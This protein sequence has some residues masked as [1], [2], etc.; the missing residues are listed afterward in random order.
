MKSLFIFAALIFCLLFFCSWGFHAHTRINYLAVLTLPEG[1]IRFYKSHI[2][3]LSA[4]AIDPD[5]RRYTDPQEGPRHFLD[6][7]NY[8]HCI[9]SIPRRWEHALEKYGLEHLQQNGI[10]PWHIQKSYLQ[11]VA[12]FREQNKRRIL[13]ISAHLAHYV[14]D[15]H[16]PLHATRNHNG[17]YTGQT[18]IHALWESLLPELFD[19]QF[20]LITGPAVYVA[21]PLAEAWRIIATSYELADSVLR[22][23]A[24]LSGEFPAYRK[25]S[26]T[27]R[28]GLL[29][30]NY[31]PEYAKA[32]D[33]RLNGMVERQMRGAV[34]MTG[35]LWYSAWVDA[36]QPMLE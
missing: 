3:Y 18:G 7:E 35:S 29:T 14:S 16:V 4:H 24:G 10:L 34:A 36:G 12:A 6:T 22:I 32:Y 2:G 28:K 26:F 1:M 19:K 27:K 20:D 13:R 9:D 17:Q 15:A 8:H 25:Y 33:Q 31:S 11:L 23:E 21:S 5:K 30:R